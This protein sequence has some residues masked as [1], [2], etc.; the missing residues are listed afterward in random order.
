[1]PKIYTIHT[2]SVALDVYQRSVVID[3]QTVFFGQVT[4][5]QVKKN[6]LV[7]SGTIKKAYAAGWNHKTDDI[8]QKITRP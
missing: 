5:E 2:A 4:T 8:M 3:G 7:I 1:M 6:T